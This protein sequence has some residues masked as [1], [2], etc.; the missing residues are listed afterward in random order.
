MIYLLD[1]IYKTGTLSWNKAY[2]IDT[3]I[4]ASTATD[5]RIN[6]KGA[7]IDVDRIAGF[8]QEGSSTDDNDLRIFYYSNG[9]IDVGV[10][11]YAGLNFPLNTNNQEYDISFGYDSNK[12]YYVYNNL[13]S[14]YIL[15]KTNKYGGNVSLNEGIK[16][17]VGGQYVH[18]LQI[19]NNG[20]VVFDGYAAFDASN[21]TIGLYDTITKTIFTNNNLSLTYGNIIG[22]ISGFELSTSALTFSSIASSSTITV[23]SSDN[24][25][26]AST[27]DSWITINPITGDTG[28]TNV[29][30]TVSSNYFT[31]RTGTV[32]FTDGKETLQLTVTQKNRV[33]YIPF[34]KLFINGDRIN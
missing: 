1:Y 28:E 21:N 33:D 17:D 6:Y 7:G 11:R 12:Y 19:T 2:N 16:I 8:S 29:T 23:T 27:T 3:G 15:S 20:I 32:S 31:D 18:S 10:S 34:K 26:T 5:V 13:T 30:V 24:P 9:T 14:S 4:Y 25:W 22:V